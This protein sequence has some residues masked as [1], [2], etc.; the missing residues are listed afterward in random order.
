MHVLAQHGHDPDVVTREVTPVYK[1]ALIAK[2]APVDAE[3]GRD[4]FRYNTVGCD[5]F[6]DCEQ[7]GDGI[8][9]LVTPPVAGVTVNVIE[10]M[11]RPFLDADSGHRVS[12]GSA[13]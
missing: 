9:R 8:Y 6:E 2:E 7:A 13:R 11:R 1:M 10:A 4:G 5:L 3:L 12:P